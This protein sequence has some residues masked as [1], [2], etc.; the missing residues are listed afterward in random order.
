[1]NTGNIIF[2]SRKKSLRPFLCTH[3]T[4][5]ALYEIALN[6]IPVPF[7]AVVPFQVDQTTYTHRTT[8]VSAR[9]TVTSLLCGHAPSHT[10]SAP[11]RISPSRSIG[12]L[13][14]WYGKNELSGA[15]GL[16]F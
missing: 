5:K 4:Q 10:D 16:R 6:F 2:L 15:P 12:K 8:F 3:T 14:L 1:M 11:M 7:N 9:M 13:L